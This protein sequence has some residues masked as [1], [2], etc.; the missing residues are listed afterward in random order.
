MPETKWYSY[1]FSG[2]SGLG[3]LTNFKSFQ[4]ITRTFQTTDDLFNILAKDALTNTLC[5]G[6]YFTTNTISIIVPEF[7]R[8]KPG[9]IARFLGIYIP[10][11]VGPV[12]SSYISLHRFVALKIQKQISY[13]WLGSVIIT[14]VGLYHLTI[15]ILF[16]YTDMRNFGFIE[17]CLGNPDQE[18]YFAKS[19][20]PLRCLV[21][22]PLMIQL[23]ATIILDIFNYKMA[24]HVTPV[25]SGMQTHQKLK[26]HIFVS[27]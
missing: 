14:L 18:A 3:I 11:V 12:V 17:A 2:I 24:T 25:P 23:L 1:L 7:L 4:Y 16:T 15:I 21:I 20:I 5:S 6:L 22:A 19:Q 26:F 13:P 8:N 10:G 27:E 9:C